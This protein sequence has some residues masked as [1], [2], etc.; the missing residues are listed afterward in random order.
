M[1]IYKG[2][3]WLPYAYIRTGLA[4]DFWSLVKAEFVETPLFD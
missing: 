1:T 4:V 3:G 2:M